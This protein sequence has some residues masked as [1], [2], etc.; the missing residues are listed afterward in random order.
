MMFAVGSV[1]VSARHQVPPA[2]FGL[3]DSINNVA[4]SGLPGFHFSRD[5]MK[6]MSPR[7]A[8]L[9]RTWLAPS[10]GGYALGLEFT[11]A[12]FRPMDDSHSSFSIL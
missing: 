9:L 5:G 7:G 1:L 8:K 2:P 12:S 10:P 11:Y 4:I 3:L 6:H